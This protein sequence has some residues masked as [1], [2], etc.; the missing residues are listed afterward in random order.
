[1]RRGNADPWVG[2]FSTADPVP[3]RMRVVEIAM[4]EVTQVF[5]R[6]RRV[7]QMKLAVR[8][9]IGKAILYQL[10]KVGEVLDGCG[11]YNDI[12]GQFLQYI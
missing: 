11:Y 5:R 7:K 12:K 6:Q 3:K 2:A 8:A 4:I 9:E 1:M 10:W